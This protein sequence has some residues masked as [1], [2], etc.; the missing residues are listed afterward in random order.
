MGPLTSAAAPAAPSGIPRD[1]QAPSD[2]LSRTHD[3]PVP[4]PELQLLLAVAANADATAAQPTAQATTGFQLDETGLTG[5]EW[6]ATRGGRSHTW[7]V[8]RTCVVAAAR[9]GQL[10]PVPYSLDVLWRSSSAPQA[11]MHL[12]FKQTLT[13][14]SRACG[15]GAW[16]SLG[17]QPRLTRTSSGARPREAHTRCTCACTCARTALR[18]RRQRPAPIRVVRSEDGRCRAVLTGT[19]RE[20]LPG[21]STK[22]RRG[23]CYAY[24]SEGAPRASNTRRQGHAGWPSRHPPIPTHNPSQIVAPARQA[25][26]L[27]TDAPPQS[28]PPV[29]VTADFAAR[30]IHE[31]PARRPPRCGKPSQPPLIHPADRLP[32]RK[33]R[34]AHF[35]IWL[36][37]RTER[38]PSGN[39]PPHATPRRFPTSS[40]ADVRLRTALQQ[41]SPPPPPRA[42]RVPPRG[43]GLCP[44]TAV[45]LASAAAALGHLCHGTS[46]RPPAASMAGSSPE[47]PRKLN[48]E[49]RLNA[50]RVI[51]TL[52]P[53]VPGARRHAYPA[54]R[55]GD[56]C[57][58][59]RA[60]FPPP[61]ARLQAEAWACGL[62]RAPRSIQPRDPRE[63]RAAA[64]ARPRH[65]AATKSW[66]RGPAARVRR[67]AHGRLRAAH[68]DGGQPR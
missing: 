45:G 25:G 5:T 47:Q 8:P 17:S 54:A 35:R 7:H 32:A 66:L 48:A 1:P 3:P 41:P 26:I 13:L 37:A 29:L 67:S 10:L 9:T 12:T 52:L 18:S 60:A 58:C 53:T 49:Q 11:R 20:G 40:P 23:V 63:D 46:A 14:S 64:L 55:I 57:A 61:R 65:D 21:A 33:I 2:A 50:K 15:R 59:G 51:Q 36:P 38:A 4:S 62:Q 44:A 24:G 31:R 28:Q 30:G 19:L 43:Q 22:G 56:G 34:A 16:P 39:P 27:S 6:G 68:G 42:S